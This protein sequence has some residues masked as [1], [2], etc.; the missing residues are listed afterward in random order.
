[1]FCRR[2]IVLD[3]G[4]EE[5]ERFYLDRFAELID[6]FPRG[7]I[8]ETES[9]GYPYALDAVRRGIPASAPGPAPFQRHVLSR[10]CEFGGR[11]P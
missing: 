5:E 9:I 10:V 2:T 11:S 3:S 6:D 4:K 8:V 1:M 7:E